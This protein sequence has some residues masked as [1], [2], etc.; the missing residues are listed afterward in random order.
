MSK[1]KKWSTAPGYAPHE[2]GY[3]FK[4]LGCDD[5]HSIRTEGPGSNWQ[6]T[7]GVDSPTVS[8]SI[9][10]RE[11]NDPIDD[12]KVTST[13]HSFIADGRIQYLSDCSHKLAGQTIDLPDF[14]I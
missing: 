6:C 4:C 5:S 7:G 8:P 2:A 14:D 1:F 10:V 9:L 12:K 11:Y 13:C 3:M